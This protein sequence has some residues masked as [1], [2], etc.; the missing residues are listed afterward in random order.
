MWAEQFAYKVTD[1]PTDQ[2]VLCCV[3]L[4]CVVLCCVVLCYS[5]VNQS[6]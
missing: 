6:D 5:L 3:V 4:C 1:W 2:H